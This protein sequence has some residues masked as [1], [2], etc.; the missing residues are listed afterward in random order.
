MMLLLRA[1][2]K[3]FTVGSIKRGKGTKI[4]AIA[5][6]DGIPFAVAVE[7]T[8]PTERKFVEALLAGFFPK[9]CPLEPVMNF[10]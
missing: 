7:S 3:G 4:V 6:G 8:S 5:S 2:K 1:R 9:N 10:A